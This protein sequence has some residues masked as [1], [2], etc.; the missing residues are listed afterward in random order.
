MPLWILLTGAL[1]TV[2]VTVLMSQLL[3]PSDEADQPLQ[4]LR[5]AG[6]TVSMPGTPKRSDQ[7]VPM[8]IVGPAADRVGPT[9]AT[10][11][12]SESGDKAYIASVVEGPTTRAFDLAEGVAGMAA[13]AGGSL[14]ETTTSRY[15]GHPAIDARVTG[16]ADGEGTLF[17]RVVHA[18]ARVFILQVIVAGDDVATAPARFRQV[19]RS[20]RITPAPAG[21]RRRGERPLLLRK[22][23]A[24]QADDE[25]ARCIAEADSAD[26]LQ[27]CG[28]D[29]VAP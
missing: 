15:R 1:T 8:T 9:R 4:P 21:G 26:A 18:G 2:L 27:R 6:F 19:V 7:P 16:V 13:A 10:S 14:R 17:A 20:L 24:A 11:Y 28:F 5:A 22:K 3:G 25:M 23:P 29:L 12:T